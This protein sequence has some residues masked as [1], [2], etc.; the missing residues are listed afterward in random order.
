MRLGTEVY[1]GDSGLYSMA[2]NE[3]TVKEPGWYLVTGQSGLES[4]TGPVS[5]RVALQ[6]DTGGGFAD[7]TGAIV[8]DDLDVLVTGIIFGSF[9]ISIIHQLTN[10]TSKYRVRGTKIIGAGDV[11]FDGGTGRLLVRRISAR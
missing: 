1:N 11:Q 7:I 3:L 9:S 10:T 4:F 8:T 5:F 2:S 6:V